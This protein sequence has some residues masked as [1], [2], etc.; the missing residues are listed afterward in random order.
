M[1]V[2]EL[3]TYRV[4]TISNFL[5]LLRIF[6]APVAWFLTEESVHDARFQY[7][8]LGLYIFIVLT[9]FLDGFLARKLGQETPLGQYLD[10]IADKVAILTAGAALVEFKGYPLWLFL[11]LIFREVLGTWGGAYLLLKKNIL[12]KPNW[13]GKTGVAAVAVSG[14]F[15]L[16][17]LPGKQWTVY[18]VFVIYLG[19]IFAYAKTYWKS[20]F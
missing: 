7:Y 20:L 6:L 9:D 15:Y 14:I 8:C 5:S 12:G 2:R 1:T 10:P 16:I 13:W 4:L 3:F 11:F 17:D 18:T 19:G